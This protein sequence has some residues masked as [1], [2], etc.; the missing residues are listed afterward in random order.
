MIV[1]GVEGDGLDFDEELV[2]SWD[3][4]W[5]GLDIERSAFRV[6]DRGEMLYRHGYGM[7]GIYGIEMCPT[8]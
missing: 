2:G 7:Y 4:G 3:W 8:T 1:D 6:E 5:A